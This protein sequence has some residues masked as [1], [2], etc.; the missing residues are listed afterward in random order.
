MFWGGDDSGPNV[1]LQC[2][3]LVRT[4]KLPEGELCSEMLPITSSAAETERADGM[5]VCAATPVG[6]ERWRSLEDCVPATHDDKQS[7]SSCSPS[8]GETKG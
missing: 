5:R 8:T 7:K 3:E 2:S 4:G 1:F 6:P